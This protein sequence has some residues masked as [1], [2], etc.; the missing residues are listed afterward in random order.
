MRVRGSKRLIKLCD[1]DEFSVFDNYYIA[2][3]E[4]GDA[5]HVKSILKM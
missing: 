5:P 1:E 4:S 3:P 2:R